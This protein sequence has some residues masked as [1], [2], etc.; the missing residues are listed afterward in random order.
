MTNLDEE[1][2]TGLEAC[3]RAP[4]RDLPAVFVLNC[5]LLPAGFVPPGFPLEALADDSG[6]D[7]LPFIVV[8]ML[9]STTRRSGGRGGKGRRACGSLALGTSD[10]GKRMPVRLSKVALLLAFVMGERFVVKCSSQAPFC[11]EAEG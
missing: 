3:L 11:R 5:V 10:Q 4:S 1:P 7:V 9:R 2:S 8:D 6:A